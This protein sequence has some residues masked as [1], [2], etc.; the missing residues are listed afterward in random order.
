MRK[1]R[2][3]RPQTHPD[4]KGAP[5][6]DDGCGDTAFHLHAGQDWSA[7]SSYFPSGRV[8]VR[9]SSTKL[10]VQPVESSAPCVFDPR[11]PNSDRRSA[12]IRTSRRLTPDGCTRWRRPAQS[13]VI[14][15]RRAGRWA[16]ARP[17]AGRPGPGRT[18]RAA[19]VGAPCPGPILILPQESSAGGLS[20]CESGPNSVHK[21]RAGI[22]GRRRRRV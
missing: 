2:T 15:P 8:L 11:P 16:D 5:G 10:R 9:S 7:G 17:C 1:E 4:R 12:M 20:S 14:H 6:D 3:A 21:G 18:S 13:T 19:W 22:R